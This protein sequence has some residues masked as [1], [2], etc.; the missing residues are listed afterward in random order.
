MDKEEI[1]KDANLKILLRN[2]NNL[3]WSIRAKAIFDLKDSNNPDVLDALI[4]KLDDDN[5]NVWLSA[6]RVL[7]DKNDSRIAEK[8]TRTLIE[9]ER[10]EVRWHSAY[11]LG[12]IRNTE[13][14][15]VPL[16][17][18]LKD[19]CVEVRVNAAKSLGKIGN[20]NEKKYYQ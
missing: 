3:N 9:D 17:N 1:C 11:Y 7:K 18:A 2:L 19:K 10:D 5:V 6:I 16:T 8:L 13:I 15:I 20:R 14:D 4:Q 12:E